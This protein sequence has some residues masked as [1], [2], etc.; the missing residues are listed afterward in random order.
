MNKFYFYTE[1]TF[2]SIPEGMDSK[3]PYH[4]TLITDSP[5]LNFQ[6]FPYALSPST[7]YKLTRRTFNV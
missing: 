2:K 6:Y 3:C 7:S 4:S 1:W 5:H